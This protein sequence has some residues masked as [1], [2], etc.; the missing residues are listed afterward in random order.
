MRDVADC[1]GVAWYLIHCLT[2]TISYE[3]ML[4]NLHLLHLQSYAM[5][6]GYNLG[7]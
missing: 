4:C 7:V 3:G 5:I 1:G 2:I 6:E